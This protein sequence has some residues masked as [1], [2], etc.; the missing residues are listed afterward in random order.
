[1]QILFA[2]FYLT[3][4]Y[5]KDQLTFDREQIG[6][7]ELKLVRITGFSA[8][9]IRATFSEIDFENMLDRLKRNDES[10]TPDLTIFCESVKPMIQEYI[11]NSVRIWL[12]PS[13]PAV[14][15]LI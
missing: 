5:D 7:F 3:R 4:F 1:M 14:V 11:P 9:V 2:F 15:G 13:S 6:A 8:D 10:S 12:S